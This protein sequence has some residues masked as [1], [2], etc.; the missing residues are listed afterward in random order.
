MTKIIRKVVTFTA[1]LFCI[2]LVIFGFEFASLWTGIIF[3]VLL[4]AISLPL[5]IFASAIPQALFE[6][7]KLSTR[8]AQILFVVLDTSATFAVLALLD[9]F[10]NDVSI[11]PISAFIIALIIA[12]FSLTDFQEKLLKKEDNG[13]LVNDR[14]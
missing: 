3:A 11:L 1:I 13:L 8:K 5:E 10:M 6:L 12:L 14:E 4:C 7:G 2:L 9:Y